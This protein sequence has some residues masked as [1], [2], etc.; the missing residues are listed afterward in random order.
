MVN[1]YI[2]PM[3]L[4]DTMSLARA[5]AVHY[6]RSGWHMFEI[7]ELISAAYEGIAEATIRFN[8]SKGTVKDTKFSSYAYFW[9]EKYLKAF[10]TVNKTMVKGTAHELYTGQVG[11]T[12]SIDAYDDTAFDGSGSDHKFWLADASQA[13]DKI[14]Q[15]ETDIARH[16]ILM[17]MLKHLDRLDRTV[18]CLSLGIG[19]V[20]REPL[21]VKDIAIAMHMTKPKVEAVLSK[22][23]AE[24]ARISVQFTAAY[25]ATL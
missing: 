22:A 11:Y 12:S 15:A 16:N 7:N 18:L 13:S 19:T 8:P 3:D 10:I 9:I 24:L 21:S 1:K 5:R 14:E 17:R 6:Q 20:D 23:N 4:Q 2:T 25:E